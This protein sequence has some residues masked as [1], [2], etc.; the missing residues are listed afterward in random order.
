MRRVVV[1]GVGIVSVLGVTR[2]AVAD[3]LYHGRSG[4]ISDPLRLAQGFRSSLTGHIADFDPARR[5]TRK[6]RKSMPDFAVQAHAAL[7]DALEQA[8]LDAD[9]LRSDRCGMVFG[10]DSTVL[11]VLEQQEALLAAGKTEGMGSGHIF[12]CMNSTITMNLNVL[13]GNT[14]AGWTVSAACASGTY[15]VGQA[16]DS[17][18]LGR[19]DRMLCGAAQELNRQAVSSFDG[20]GAFSTRSPAEEASRPFDRGRDGL[21]PSGGAAALVLEEYETARKRGAPMLAEILGFGCS[22]DGE[23]LSLPSHTGPARAMRMA[24]RDAKLAPGDIDLINAHATSTPPGDAAEAANLRSVFAGACPPVMALKS[25]TGHELWMSGASQVVYAVI[26]AERGF[27][28]GTRNFETPDESTAGIPVLDRT[29]DTPPRT[30]L[31]NASGFGGS[32]A[33]L[34]LRL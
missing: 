10:N 29:V 3:S 32:N 15:A 17:I 23:A 7:M 2:E 31:C 20:L 11:P 5:L 33:C 8:G 16:A 30:V 14:G 6:Q 4:V 27:T 28:A 22:A 12:R 21:V 18:R 24:L 19:Q 9:D 1:T 34:V 13:F 25:L 26:M